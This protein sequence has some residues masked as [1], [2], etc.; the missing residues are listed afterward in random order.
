MCVYYSGVILEFKYRHAMDLQKSAGGT[1]TRRL[2]GIR[3]HYHQH[4]AYINYKRDVSSMYTL[5]P[6]PTLSTMKG[7]TLELKPWF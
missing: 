1:I 7:K 5:I 4:G 2:R 6:P 3:L